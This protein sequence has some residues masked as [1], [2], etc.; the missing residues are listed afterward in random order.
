MFR[1]CALL[2]DYLSKITNTKFLDVVIPVYSLIE[3]SDVIQK[4]LEVYVKTNNKIF[5]NKI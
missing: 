5:Y 4:H 1:N 3:Y 2:S